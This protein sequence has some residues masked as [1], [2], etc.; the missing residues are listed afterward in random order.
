VDVVGPAVA[1]VTKKR[2]AAKA[3][4]RE[5]GALM[6]IV[7]SPSPRQKGS[8]RLRTAEAGAK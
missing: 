7:A 1:G 8:R 4:D 2:T 3:A 6:F 5:H